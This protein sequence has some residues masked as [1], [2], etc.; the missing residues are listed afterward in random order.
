MVGTALAR[1]CPPYE[2]AHAIVVT[3]KSGAERE[4][5]SES[6]Q[7]QKFHVFVPLRPSHKAGNADR[8]PP[9]DRGIVWWLVTAERVGLAN[10]QPERKTGCLP[11]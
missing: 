11:Q 1:L 6:G 3:R 9:D 7:R 4:T 8:A 10:G 5:K 2:Y